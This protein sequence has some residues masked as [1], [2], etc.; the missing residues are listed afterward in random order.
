LL[1]PYYRLTLTRPRIVLPLCVLLASELLVVLAARK[2]EEERV[3]G[4]RDE[5]EE[6]W[7]VDAEDVMERE[8]ARE[9]KVMDEG[10][11]YLRVVF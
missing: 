11:H 10:C 2:D 6:V 5:G 8:A 1:V 3:G 9:S 7:I 4:A